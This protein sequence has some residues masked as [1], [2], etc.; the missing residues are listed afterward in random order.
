MP[1]YIDRDKLP[2]FQH[3]NFCA[4]PENGWD[5]G[6]G[7][8]AH[9]Y[10]LKNTDFTP[11]VLNLD[12]EDDDIDTEKANRDFKELL[13]YEKD[14]PEEKKCI[15]RLR[16]EWFGMLHEKDSQAYKISQLITFTL[17]AMFKDFSLAS[18]W[19]KRILDMM[20]SNPKPGRN[21]ILSTLAYID[22]YLAFALR[23]R[24]SQGFPLYFADGD[25][26]YPKMLLIE[27]KLYKQH[28]GNADIRLDYDF[29]VKTLGQ[30]VYVITVNGE[31][32]ETYNR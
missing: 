25:I 17:H 9:A 18:S 5:F 12:Y 15:V 3:Y 28:K 10:Y 14:T 20:R 11:I 23:L 7:E 13:T 27:D 29:L 30:E 1:K 8:G 19:E 6:H 21:E 31:S 2:Q 22:E 24:C 4:G 16:L 32:A 26:S